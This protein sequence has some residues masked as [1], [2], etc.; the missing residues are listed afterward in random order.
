MSDEITILALK[1][2]SDPTRMKIVRFL[3]KYPRGT[4]P[5]ASQICFHITGAEK[6]TST[7]SHHIHELDNAGLVRIERVG[8]QMICSLR[9]EAFAYLARE[10]R[11]IAAQAVSG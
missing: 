9:P 7:I 11:D 1:A 10:F 5:T 2:L 3:L 6:I 4:G 8:K